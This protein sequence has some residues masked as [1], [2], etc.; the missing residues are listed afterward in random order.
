MMRLWAQ[1]ARTG[2]P[3]VKNLT[4]WPAYDRT[5]DKYLYLNEKLEVKSGYSRIPRD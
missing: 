5:S 3:A 1:F 4:E 2:N